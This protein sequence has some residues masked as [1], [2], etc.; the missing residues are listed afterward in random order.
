M[1]YIYHIIHKPSGKRYIGQSAADFGDFTRIWEHFEI[2]YYQNKKKD[3]ADTKAL[4]SSGSISDFDI[5]VF[6]ESNDYGFEYT[7]VEENGQEIRVSVFDAFLRV[8]EHEGLRFSSQ[9][10]EHGDVIT[11]QNKN[12][13]TQQL[14]LRAL[15]LDIAEILHTV[16]AADRG[17]KLT[18]DEL[19]GE[20]SYWKLVGSKVQTYALRKKMKPQEAL[21]VFR[22]LNEHWLQLTKAV[23]VATTELMKNTCRT[24]MP[25]IIEYVLSHKN[26]TKKKF[27]EDVV[28]LIN[29]TKALSDYHLE[30]FKEKVRSSLKKQNV[31]I[32][33]NFKFLHTMRKNMAEFIAEVMSHQ[34]ESITHG[35]QL[36]TFWD[37]KTK[38]SF[39][40][41]MVISLNKPGNQDWWKKLTSNAYLI[42]ELEKQK[43]SLRF[44]TEIYYRKRDRKFYEN[45][46]VTPPK[47]MS[48]YK[49]PKTKEVTRKVLQTGRRYDKM[50][51][52]KFRNGLSMDHVIHSLDAGQYSMYGIGYVQYDG[53]NDSLL[54]KMRDY[55][56]SILHGNNIALFRQ[57][58]FEN[59][60]QIMINNI[61][62]HLKWE[63]T[64]T[65]ERQSAW[66][67][68]DAYYTQQIKVPSTF[69]KNILLYPAYGFQ[70]D[71][72][73]YKDLSI[74]QYY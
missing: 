36:K 74:L 20:F 7:T 56:Q 54:E 69:N 73:D 11:I 5:M 40:V 39:Q 31:F 58:N 15:K 68:H 49:D 23:R 53:S 18:N 67:G 59:F 48:F 10:F 26:I 47:T 30:L 57:G 45:I 61:N 35:Y 66:K 63:S 13:E 43:Q 64:K 17:I 1:A 60:Y 38:F 14:N 33:I 32:S 12:E 37:G 24:M 52:E 71:P 27:K 2:I 65:L 72:K 16:N 34:I 62:K 22:T 8:F 9:V 4:I 41:P 6:D 28:P 51:R 21:G 42:S 25:D 19:G 44:F 70:H 3:N 46:T 29:T 55:Y 50:R